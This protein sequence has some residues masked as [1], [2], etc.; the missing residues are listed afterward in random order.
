MYWI[1]G[2]I[3]AIIYIAIIIG[4]YIACKKSGN[5]KPLVWVLL[6]IFL[7]PIGALVIYLIIYVAKGDKSRPT[8]QDHD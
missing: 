8:P 6:A 2:I 5:A 7:T 1:N 4:I 3:P